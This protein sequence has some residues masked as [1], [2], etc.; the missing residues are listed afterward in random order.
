MAQRAKVLASRPDGLSSVSRNHVV[1]RESRLLKVA[2]PPCMCV[3]L[4]VP[5]SLSH[6]YTH[7]HKHT[8][9]NTSEHTL[10]KCN[11]FKMLIQKYTSVS[12]LA[13]EFT[14]LLP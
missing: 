2:P 5:V 8:Q 4:S 14:S 13:C 3:S 10:N 9:V 7:A 12:R 11:H 6:T 1:G